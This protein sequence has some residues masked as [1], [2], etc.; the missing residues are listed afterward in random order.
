M[1]CTYTGLHGTV[2]AYETSCNKTH[3]GCCH[4]S[5]LQQ[6]LQREEGMEPHC[7][8]DRALT[9]QES[10]ILRLQDRTFHRVFLLG[11]KTITTE[12]TSVGQLQRFS[13][14]SLH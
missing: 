12:T 10:F 7:M 9:L 11:L 5:S 4:L 1:F 13:L 8:Q 14:E 2:D 3:G 6:E